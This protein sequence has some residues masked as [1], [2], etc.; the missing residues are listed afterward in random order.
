MNLL[1]PIANA[2]VLLVLAGSLASWAWVVRQLNS[3]RP[4]VAWSARGPVPWGL[5]QLIAL[6]FAMIALQVALQ[7]LL[8][9]S[10]AVDSAG[11]RPQDLEADPEVMLRLMHASSTA[12]V[13]WLAGAWWFLTRWQG[14]AAEEAGWNAATLKSDLLLGAAAFAV[15]APIVY[16]LQY[17]L[18]QYWPSRHPL[19][20]AVRGE[21]GSRLLLAAAISAVIMAPL[22][23]EFAFRML[24]QGWFE[25]LSAALLG[26]RQRERW[27]PAD[28]SPAATADT[29][30][31]PATSAT[32]APQ[33]V[34]TWSTQVW[35]VLLLGFGRLPI[36]KGL[37]GTNLAALRELDPPHPLQTAVEALPTAG[38]VWR[39]LPVVA[40]SLIFALLHYSHGP[41]WVPLLVLALGLGYLYQRTHR[42]VPC[43]VVHALLNGVSFLLLLGELASDSG[44]QP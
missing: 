28:P 6:L 43:I 1:P 40:S 10:R 31:T 8:L 36:P 17:V 41:D 37:R 33:D 16:G 35:N 38:P 18:V 32:D 2:T 22:F 7:T 14:A 5:V 44:A 24:L 4:L 15:L 21:D 26:H 34:E 11:G 13:L 42:L 3:R 12:Y 30:G 19:V 25:N 29:A 9:G 27:A 39:W 23:E 20:E